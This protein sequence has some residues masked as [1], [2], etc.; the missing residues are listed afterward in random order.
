MADGKVKI[1]TELDNSGF[2]S[3]L[4][5]MKSSA[6]RGTDILKGAFT[7]VGVGIAGMATAIGT[8]GFKFNMQMENYQAGFTAL[9]GSTD[10]ATAMVK[11]LQT[12]AAKTPFELTDLAK[13][14]QTLLG[15][16]ME[17]EK[18]IPTLK[19]IGDISMGNK[20]RFQAL[21]L[22]FAQVQAAGKLT[23][24]DLL[25]MINAGFNPL[26]IISEKT[27]K[28]IA[29]PRDEMSDG[30]ISA[31]MVA[32]AFKSATA[33]GGR[34]YN[35]MEIQSKTLEGQWSTIMDN[36]NQ[37]SGQVIKPLY[38]MIASNLLPIIN[39]LMSKISYGLE[40]RQWFELQ[41]VMEGLAAIGQVV[42]GS[43]D[44]FY[45]RILIPLGDTLKNL[46]VP[47]ISDFISKVGYGLKT[48]N[49]GEFTN[50]IQGINKA[51]AQAFQGITEFTSKVSFGVKTRDWKEFN[52]LVKTI[53]V[54]LGLAV[55]AFAGFKAGMAIQ[56]VI[57][58]FQTASM[59]IGIYTAGIAKV[60]V[61][62]GLLAT[63]ERGLAIAKGLVNGQLTIF[64][65]LIALVTGQVSLATIATAA[66]TAAQKALNA[67]LTANPYG[68]VVALVAALTTGLIM[69]FNALSKVNLAVAND[70]TKGF[71]N[72]TNTVLNA[73][74]N[75]EQFADVFASY[76]AK[77]TDIQK[78]IQEVQAGITSIT[79][80][81]TAER[82]ALTD[83][84]IQKLDEYFKKLRELEKQELQIMQA[85]AQAVA[86]QTQNIL[87]N[88]N[89]SA[90]E[91]LANG[92]KW[93]ANQ[94]E[95]DTQYLANID[96][97]RVNEIA[98]LNQRFGD[99]ANT[100]NQAYV[101]QLAAINTHYDQQ[102]QVVSAGFSA[103][104][105]KYVEGYAKLIGVDQEYNTK[106]K[107]VM[108]DREGN[109][110][111]QNVSM[112]DEMTRHTKELEYINT[113]YAN[114]EGRR[115][116]LLEQENKVHNK[117]MGS[118]WLE[119]TEG[120]DETKRQ[121]LSTLI[122]MVADASSKGGDVETK[123]GDMTKGI[124]SELDKLPPDTKKSMQ[125]AMQPLIDTVDNKKPTIL[126]RITTLG[127]DILA[128]LN[129]SFKNASP[130]KETRKIFQNVMKGMMAGI[131]IEENNLFNKVDDV[132]GRLKAAMNLN[133][134]GIE[135]SL[136]TGNIY[137]KAYNTLPVYVNGTYTSNLL[138]DGEVLATTVNNVDQRRNLQYGY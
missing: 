119:L 86:T 73:K 49:W 90:E 58:A 129:K 56:G 59:Q 135:A 26:L 93:L 13:A 29:Q 20:E 63:T 91:Y 104:W 83:S 75:L 14:S 78:G 88:L 39:E 133:A 64:Q 87:D 22:A 118:I 37:L 40:T 114:D 24:Q 31:E 81:A 68:A 132:F 108:T 99:Q 71:D 16:G 9:L 34:F 84:E 110:T 65:G 8:A 72:F 4:D 107:A 6:S 121:Q 1:Q 54:S 106:V 28:S 52:G 125:N 124:V 51:F 47:V 115:N 137:N 46:V 116:M 101:D 55:V 127:S 82:R 130:S 100:T 10:K 123:I 94:E 44:F 113:T 136:S 102:Q 11:N 117:N 7:A 42:A 2:V 126:Q 80:L 111:V 98:A 103:Q 5:K 66:W 3:G 38:T 120:M 138:V 25:Q 60:T 21:S 79:N 112:E 96:K 122:G 128:A 41:G 74:S 15:F 53:T 35:A 62:N 109:Q 95:I 43:F 134:T 30:A 33:E 67:V 92:A 70:M 77:G 36:F 131:D 32:D 69:L 17:A 23:G 45:R 61:A 89:V 19:N 12:M 97:A 57:A 85:K 18:V 50:I 48:G 76:D 105:T 27:G